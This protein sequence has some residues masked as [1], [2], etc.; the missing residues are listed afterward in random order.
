VSS[1]PFPSVLTRPRAAMKLL[2]PVVCSLRASECCSSFGISSCLKFRALPKATE[3]VTCAR[4]A[5]GRIG[6]TTG[7]LQVV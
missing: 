7:I 6:C 2:L 5:Q 1:I 3:K 4:L